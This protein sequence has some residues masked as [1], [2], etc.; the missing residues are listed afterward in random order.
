MLD[1]EDVD[2]GSAHVFTIVFEFES[3]ELTELSTAQVVFIV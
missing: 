3:G 1:A 2:S